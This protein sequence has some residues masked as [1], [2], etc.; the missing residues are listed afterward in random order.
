MIAAKHNSNVEL[1]EYTHYP[2][3]TG[4]LRGVSCEDIGETFS[5]YNGTTLY[6]LSMLYYMYAMRSFINFP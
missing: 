6:T 2:A 3:L 1:T 4:E 5:R